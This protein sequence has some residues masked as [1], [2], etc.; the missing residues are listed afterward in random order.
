LLGDNQGGAVG[1]LRPLRFWCFEV[2]ISFVLPLIYTHTV[3]SMY[4][5]LRLKARLPERNYCLSRG[6]SVFEHNRHHYRLAELDHDFEIN[7]NLNL[8]KDAWQCKCFR[9]HMN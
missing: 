8:V 7:T 2:W 1:M 9:T 3:E 5:Q 4:T 6:V